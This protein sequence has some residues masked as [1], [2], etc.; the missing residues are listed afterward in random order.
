MKHIKT[1]MHRIEG[2]DNEFVKAELVYDLGGVNVWTYKVDPR[3]YWVLIRRVKKERGFESFV[4]Y[5]GRKILLTETSRQSKKAEAEAEARFNAEYLE[6]IRR[7]YPNVKLST[8]CTI[9]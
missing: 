8:G 6:M 9:M 5:D 2:T 7:V 3:G 1:I 4:L